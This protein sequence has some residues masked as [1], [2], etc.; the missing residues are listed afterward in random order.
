MKRFLSCFVIALFL[1]VTA[2]VVANVDTFEAIVAVGY[3]EVL[4]VLPVSGTGYDGGV[5]LPYEDPDAPGTGMW[6]N[7]W[8]LNGGPIEGWKEIWY[9]MIVIPESPAPILGVEVAINWSDRQWQEVLAPPLPG[10]GDTRI[11]R[12]TVWSGDIDPAAGPIFIANDLSDPYLIEDFNPVWVSID[13]RVYDP[14]GLS[15]GAFRITGAIEHIH[16]PIPAP[17]A[18]L[19][20]GIG[21]GLVGW[22]RRRRTL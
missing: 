15:E 2:N 9:D 3:G 8:F 11:E 1:L 16:H 19:L 17:G 12:Y 4:L 7:Q 20:G 10:T 18:V 21:V 14:T 22:M 6:W 13:V 5:W